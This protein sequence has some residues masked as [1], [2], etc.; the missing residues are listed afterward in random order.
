MLSAQH[1]K[2]RYVVAFQNKVA[3]NTEFNVVILVKLRRG[4]GRASANVFI[5]IVL[6]NAGV[7]TI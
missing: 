6:A 7:F 2:L 3:R 5:L 4:A 1:G